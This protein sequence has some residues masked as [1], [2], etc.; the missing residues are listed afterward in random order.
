[1]KVYGDFEGVDLA[2]GIRYRRISGDGESR[3]VAH[4]DL[5]ELLKRIWRDQ[6]PVR[7][8]LERDSRPTA[9]IM[10]FILD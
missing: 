6:A 1:M 8:R 5:D 4:G 9:E 10:N 3:L 2:S 7:E